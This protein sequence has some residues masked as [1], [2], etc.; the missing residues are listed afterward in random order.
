MKFESSQ[1]WQGKNSFCKKSSLRINKT[2]HEFFKFFFYS[3]WWL[4]ARP[5]HLVYCFGD[6]DS[7]YCRGLSGSAGSDYIMKQIWLEFNSKRWSI[8]CANNKEK[9]FRN[10]KDFSQ[11]RH[12]NKQTK[13]HINSLSCHD[14]I[15]TENNN[16]KTQVCVWFLCVKVSF[17]EVL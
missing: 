7:R 5:G 11:S 12:K 14:K 6:V 9:T 16:K 15:L 3:R 10:F 4:T 2:I 1:R 17:C 8:V 13:I